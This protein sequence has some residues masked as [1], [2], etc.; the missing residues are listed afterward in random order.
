MK[1]IAIPLVLVAL[2]L[3]IIGCIE[4]TTIV[5]LRE[6]GS[7][8]IEETFLLRNDVI[9]AFERAAAREGSDTADF[10][11]LDVAKLERRAREMGDGAVLK[12]AE[13]LTT[14]TH[15][16]YRAVFSFEDINTIRINENPDE[17][18]PESGSASTDADPDSAGF[19]PEKE[20]I[21]FNFRRPSEG[22]PASLTIRF[23][24]GDEDMTENPEM[25][26]MS[27]E[28]EEK[29][30]GMFR[31]LIEDMKIY[32]ALEVEGTITETNAMYIEGSKVVLMDLD[33]GKIVE[34]EEVFEKLVKSQTD[35][36]EETKELIKDLPGIRVE[37]QDAIEVEFGR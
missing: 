13:D 9:R 5:H 36:I 20:M 23:P 25:D 33:F 28:Q 37:M 19:E 21:G 3:S 27:A 30:M 15:Q 29:M 31:Q 22:K 35:S 2:F 24:H 34:N 18:V 7:G 4:S 32:I 8:E 10:K 26:E 1:R 16:G 17:N 11:I 12:S 14:S 6:D